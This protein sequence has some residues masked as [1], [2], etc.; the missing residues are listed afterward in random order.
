MVH[1]YVGDNYAKYKAERLSESISLTAPTTGEETTSVSYYLVQRLDITADAE[2]MDSYRDSAL[3][4]LKYE[5][6]ETSLTEKASAY[7]VTENAA[8]MKKYTI[9][10]L[11]QV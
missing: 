4:E 2:T 8:A 7:A 5:E 3:H 1:F 11:G 6:L 10:N 9:E